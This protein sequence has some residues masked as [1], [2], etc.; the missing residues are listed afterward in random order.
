ME[1]SNNN[2]LAL[3]LDLNQDIEEYAEAT[4]KNIIE[5]KNFDFLTY[6]PN[7]GLT[8]LE[9]QELNKLDNNEHLKNALRKVIADNSAGIVFNMLNIID[10]TT[11]PKLMYDEWTGIKLIDQDLNEDA[12]EFQDMLHDSFYESYWKWRELR[13][14]KNWKLDTYEE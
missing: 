11:D 3:M 1:L 13:G 5:D 7:S 9:K 12:D 8:D 6:P 14:D 10:G 2:A 4:V